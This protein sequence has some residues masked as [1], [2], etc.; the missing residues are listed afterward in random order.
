MK[1]ISLWGINMELIYAII[2]I[3]LLIVILTSATLYIYHHIMLQ[4]E[5]PKIISIGRSVKVDGYKMN[6]YTEG[7]KK[8]DTAPTIVLLSGSGVASPIYDYKILYSKL[9][10]T[11][12]VAVIEKF[13]YGY[14][15]ISGLPRDVATMVEQDRKALI[16]AGIHPP[17]ILMPHSMSALETIYWT[18]QYPDEVVKIIG[19]DMAVPDSYKKSNVHRI[20]FLKL[21]TSLG[22]HRIPALYPIDRADLTDYE[23]EQNKVLTYRNSLNKDVYQE[24]KMVLDN[25]KAVENMP[26]PDIPI[27]MFTTNLGL[28]SENNEWKLAQLDFASKVKDC[29]QVEMDCGHELH[30]YFS[31]DIAHRIKEF[32]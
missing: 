14:S 9:S 10:D 31:D 24:C 2:L 17:Y 6:V 18:N 19:L 16:G 4:K 3:V 26:I 12:K 20:R 30:Y 15:D 25:A 13:G 1:Q 27:L 23:Y 11:Y 29:I 5:V 32:L 28:S 7:E 22:L 8:E 21:M